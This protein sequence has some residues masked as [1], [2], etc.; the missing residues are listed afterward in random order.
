LEL[1]DVEKLYVEAFTFRKA[2]E[3]LRREQLDLSFRDFPAGCC[4]NTSLLLGAYF[5][6]NG[7]GDFDYVCG[8]RGRQSHA[9]LEKDG[10][11]VDITSDQ[12]KEG[13]KV[14]VGTVNSFYKKFREERRYAWDAS[15]DGGSMQ[16]DRLYPAYRAIIKEIANHQ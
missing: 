14:Y 1:S 5:S 3:S 2:I 16:T 9:W 4:G 10:I 13:T 6:L 8:M 11:I 12:F 7:L 15:L